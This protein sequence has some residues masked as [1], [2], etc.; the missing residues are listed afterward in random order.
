VIDAFTALEAVEN[1]GSSS[2]RSAGMIIVIGRLTASS[3]V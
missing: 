3:A 1:G 2:C